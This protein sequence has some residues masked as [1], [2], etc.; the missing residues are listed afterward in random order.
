MGR[1]WERRPGLSKGPLL[2]S[3]L[4]QK[5]LLSPGRG[6]IQRTDGTY[7]AAARPEHRSIAPRF[8]PA[9]MLWSDAMVPPNTGDVSTHAITCF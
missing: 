1:P 7:S 2:V 6:H 5:Y 8:Q 9:K 3:V 4:F